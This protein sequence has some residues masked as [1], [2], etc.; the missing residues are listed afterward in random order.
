MHKLKFVKKTLLICAILCAV[1]CAG[2]QGGRIDVIFDTDANNELDDQHAIAYLLMNPETFNTL[3]ITTNNTRNGGGIASQSE[4]ARRITALC[5]KW[6]EGV[7]VIDGA[8]AAFEDIT[9]TLDD[10]AF[11]GVEA[12]DFIIETALGY[13]PERKLT[14]IAVGKLTNV[15]LALQK[16]PQI[17]PNIRLVWLGSNYP[18]P[19]EYN[20]VDDIPSMNYVLDT[21]VEFEIVTVRYKRPDGTSAV[22]ITPAFAEENFGGKGPQVSPV[23]G[24]HGGEFTC[25]GDYSVNLFH[26]IKLG[27]DGKRALYDLC[28]VAVVKNPAWATAVQIPAPTMVDGRWVERA[29]NPRK[30]TLW[31][32]FDRDGIV[33]DLTS[34][35]ELCTE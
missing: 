15:A 35:L 28:A 34:T 17:S 1:A 16:A 9:A 18:D 20:L 26:N 2:Q 27:A 7:R 4:E 19:G 5:G 30:L 14:L 31:E 13:A 32:N 29:E 6:G 23:E 22:R 10:P 24:R 8:E 12:V 21:D 25:F 3:A 33:G 11:D